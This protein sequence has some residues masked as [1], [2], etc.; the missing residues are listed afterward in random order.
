MTERLK[1][2]HL[3]KVFTDKPAQ[4]LTMLQAGKTKSDVQQELGQVVGGGVVMPYARKQPTPGHD[5]I[6][7]D[8]WWTNHWD[9]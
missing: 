4:A 9:I 5:G 1:I 7:M 8:G 3:Y 2:E 6:I